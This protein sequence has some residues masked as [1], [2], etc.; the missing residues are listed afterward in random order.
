MKVQLYLKVT[1]LVKH[2]RQ[3]KKEENDKLE[4]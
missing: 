2:F 3:W 1:K 4:K